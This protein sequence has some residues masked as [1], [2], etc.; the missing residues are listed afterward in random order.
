MFHCKRILFTHCCLLE[1]ISENRDNMYPLHPLSALC[2]HHLGAASKSSVVGRHL[3]HRWS[4]VLSQSW[5]SIKKSSVVGRY[6]QDLRSHSCDFE[7]AV[8][9]VL[10]TKSTA[11]LVLSLVSLSIKPLT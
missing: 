11:D 1:S 3:R 10:I 9:P 8:T 4:V 6:L 2:C 7:V 5:D